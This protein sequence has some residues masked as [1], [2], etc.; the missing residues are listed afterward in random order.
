MASRT[1]GTNDLFFRLPSIRN[2]ASEE[3]YGRT[4]TI[5]VEE[6]LATESLPKI[7]MLRF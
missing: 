7:F 1:E 6:T 5:P 4:Q 3:T 2:R